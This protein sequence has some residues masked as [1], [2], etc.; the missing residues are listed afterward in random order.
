[1]KLQLSTQ[2]ENCLSISKVGFESPASETFVYD[3]S[4]AHTSLRPGPSQ[5]SLFFEH[6]RR[7]LG[8]ILCWHSL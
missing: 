2:L 1:M 7:K 3:F 5:N 6:F 4:N 8:Q